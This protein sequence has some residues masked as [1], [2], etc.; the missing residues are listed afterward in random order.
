MVYFTGFMAQK[1][2]KYKLKQRHIKIFDLF[3]GDNSEE[4]A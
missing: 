3:F 4:K 2:E 1:D